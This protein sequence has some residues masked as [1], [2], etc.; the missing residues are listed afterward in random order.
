MVELGLS[1]STNVRDL[2]PREERRARPEPNDEPMV[3]IG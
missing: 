3:Q 2:D 1:E